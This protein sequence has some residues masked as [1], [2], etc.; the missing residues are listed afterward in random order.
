[1][2]IIKTAFSIVRTAKNDVVIVL[3][4]NKKL[5]NTKREEIEMEWSLEKPL[6]SVDLFLSKNSHV[7]HSKRLDQ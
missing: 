5:V 4:T 1:M 2:K 6:R 3:G 7:R